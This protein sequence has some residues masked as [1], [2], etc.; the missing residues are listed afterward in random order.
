MP[1][2]ADC[3]CQLA[4][5]FLFPSLPPTTIFPSAL[6]PVPGAP[7]SYQAAEGDP[8]VHS[9]KLPCLLPPPMSPSAAHV[10]FH[11]SCLLPSPMSP[12]AVDEATSL[13]HHSLALVFIA[14]IPRP[15]GLT[16]HKPQAH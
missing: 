7:A 9:K 3:S 13:R 6:V 15:S 12:S 16:I 1:R 4:A 5:F 10:S 2:T 8:F 11:R 14:P